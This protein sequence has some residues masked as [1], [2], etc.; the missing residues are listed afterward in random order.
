M[1]Y[2]EE[3]YRGKKVAVTGGASFI[4]SH[5]V[6]R[7]QDFGANV[8]VLDDLSSGR[9]ENL[10]P[11]TELI[12]ADLV[13]IHIA[14]E[15]LS[16]ADIVF[17]LAAV[18]GG[19]GFIETKQRAMLANMAIDN[20]IFTSSKDASMIVHA[21]SACAYPTNL[22]DSETDRGFLREESVDLNTPAGTF[23]DGVYGWTKLM[24]E[25]QL[26]TIVKGSDRFGRSARIF[27]AYGERENE[28]HAVIA[29]I[30]KALLG[31]DPYSIWGSGE[32]TR[33]FT[34]VG[35]TV[36]GLLLL[37][38]DVSGENFQALNIGT[39]VHTTVNDLVSEI[40]NLIGWQPAE[41]HRDLTKPAGV[42]SRASD[43]SLLLSKFGWQPEVSVREGL[44]KT[45]SWYQSKTDK[46]NS[47]SELQD[48][49]MS[50]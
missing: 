10:R 50:R 9:R 12:E 16:G 45:I 39:S 14:R 19:R 23:P 18:H 25:M 21:S 31:M 47:L 15:N 8:T 13:D 17:H 41:I 43:N 26:E 24:G 38:S 3:F 5:L 29:L 33:N 34:Y 6:D 20:N 11:G 49:L 40:F 2:M 37:G 44:E 48:I 42:G 28:S 32:Q 4:G 46:P 27:T 22:Q 7:L 30:A 36:H 35:D 1:D